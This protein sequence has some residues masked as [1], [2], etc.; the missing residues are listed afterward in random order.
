MPQ[1]QQLTEDL[2]A[3]EFGDTRFHLYESIWRLAP[4]VRTFEDIMD[5]LADVVIAIENDTLLPSWALDLAERLPDGH[6]LLGVCRSEFINAAHY[7]EIA[8]VEAQRRNPPIVHSDQATI[9]SKLSVGHGGRLVVGTLNYDDSILAGSTVFYDGF[10]HKRDTAPFDDRFSERVRRQSKALLWLH[11]CTH[12]NINGGTDRLPGILLGQVFWTGDALQAARGWSGAQHN[13]RLELPLVIGADK[14]RQILRAPFINYWAT[15]SDFA[16]VV[17]RLVVIGYSG[18]DEHLNRILQNIVKWR[19]A[20][21]KVVISTK[22]A[23]W[24]EA[25]PM[26]A[27]VFGSPF[28]KHGLRI[29]QPA[30]PR[31]SLQQVLSLPVPTLPKVWVDLDGVEDLAAPVTLEKLLEILQ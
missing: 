3:R 2:R 14:P 1:T 23:S 22:A 18:G 17:D 10:D 4:N 12:F 28:E 19:G 15:L 16:T 24:D 27:K 11:G 20:E 31:H 7:I 26:L 9:C 29:C 13:G 5:C 6:N 30:T 8:L 21:L 25:T